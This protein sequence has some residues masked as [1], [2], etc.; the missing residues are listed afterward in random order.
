MT[1]DTDRGASAVVG[2]IVFIAIVAFGVATIAAVQFAT[3]GG[4]NVPD[5]A[6]NGTDTPSRASD[7]PTD[8]QQCPKD[9][10]PVYSDGEIA[11]CVIDNI[12]GGNDT[13][14]VESPT[15][16]SEGTYL[17]ESES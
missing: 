14:S 11:Y 8:M 17:T 4:G 7:T 2:A 3:D 1:N 5:N 16:E 12:D 15:A 6:T 9:R 10:T 13:P